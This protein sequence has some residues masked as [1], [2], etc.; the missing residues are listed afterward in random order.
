MNG[1]VPLTFTA[2][3][4]VEP[5]SKMV[6]L[7][8]CTVT[9]G[10]SFGWNAMKPHHVPQRSRFSSGIFSCSVLRVSAYIWMVHMSVSLLGSTCAAL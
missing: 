2:S 5:N 7:V 3:E 4:T 8:G 6:W 10:G 9:T 1:P